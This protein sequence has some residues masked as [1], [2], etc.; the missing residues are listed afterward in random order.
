VKL[1]VE[2]KEFNLETNLAFTDHMKASEK[3]KE[4]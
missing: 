3:V 4:R 2:K 1:L